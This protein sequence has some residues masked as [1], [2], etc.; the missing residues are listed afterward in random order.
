MKQYLHKHTWIHLFP[1]NRRRRGT[2]FFFFRKDSSSAFEIG[3]IVC[4]QRTGKYMFRHNF[5]IDLSKSWLTYQTTVGW[6]SATIRFH[7]LVRLL[8]SW[9]IGTTQN[10]RNVP[11]Y[12]TM[13]GKCVV[14]CISFHPTPVPFAWHAKYAF[15]TI[16]SGLSSLRS[17][18][19][20]DKFKH[21]HSATRGQCVIWWLKIVCV[22]NSMWGTLLMEAR[23]SMV[24][25][26]AWAS[27]RRFSYFALP[28]AIASSN[29][30]SARSSGLSANRRRMFEFSGSNYR[31]WMLGA[32]LWTFDGSTYSS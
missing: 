10:I 14:T 17:F 12:Q 23:T 2:S 25:R 11:R 7:I 4:K 21:I 20:S 13:D 27:A 19:W 8:Q 30:G 24:F 29:C 6:Y 5:A 31:R 3:D 15:C 22:G 16:I 26:S 18:K 28:N 9:R 1:L 32:W